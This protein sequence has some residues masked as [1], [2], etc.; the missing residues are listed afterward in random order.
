MML[1]IEIHASPS[2]Y[3]L[4][5]L[6]T[7]VLL[8][9]TILALFRNSSFSMQ[10]SVFLILIAIMV[11]NGWEYMNSRLNREIVR[12]PKPK[13]TANS[14]KQRSFEP[15]SNYNAK[16]EIRRD[17]SENEREKLIN[18]ETFNKEDFTS[19]LTECSPEIWVDLLQI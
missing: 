1:K 8:V 19:G 7:H 18:R 9:C 6:S 15:T 11:S 3:L 16:T 10:M 4:I 17:D 2:D 14:G 13:A 5:K 12:I